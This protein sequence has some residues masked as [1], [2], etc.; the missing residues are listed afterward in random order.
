MT[1][2]ASIPKQNKKGEF[3]EVYVKASLSACETRDTKGLYSKARSGE[4]NDFTG[5][6]AP[7]EEPEKPELIIDTECLNQ[8]QSVGLLIDFLKERG[9]IFNTQ[10]Q[11][12]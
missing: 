2:R 5:I 12:A 7:Y 11:Q 8:E 10:G 3:I 4:I 1:L 6:S 9:Y